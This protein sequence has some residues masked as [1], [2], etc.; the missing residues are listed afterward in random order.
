M[1]KLDIKYRFTSLDGAKIDRTARTVPLS[2]S[3]EFPAMQRNDF[4]TDI[5]RSA[6]LQKGQ[7]YIEVLDHTTENVDLSRLKNRGAF[8]DEHDEKDQIGVVETAEISNS[9]KIGR[10]VVKLDAH[11]KAT[12]RFS[13][14]ESNSRPHISAG[15]KYTRFLGDT[16]LPNGKKAKRFA[17]A[18]LELSSVAV[19]A[20]PTIGVSRSDHNF[21][22]VIDSSENLDV[23]AIAKN[24]TPEQKKRM[25]ILLNPDPAEGALT[26]ADVT[27]ARTE[28]ETAA[29]KAERARAGEITKVADELIKARKNLEPMIRNLASEALTTGMSLG[30][31]QIRAM[32]DVIA[33]KPTKELSAVEMGLSERDEKEYSIS[34][35][36]RSIIKA[37]LK[38]RLP[39]GLELEVHQEMVRRE[40]EDGG[41]IEASG[42]FVPSWAKVRMSPTGKMTRDL[43]AGVFGQGGATVA[44]QLQVPIIELLRNMMVT[45]G[46]GIRTLAGL[47]GNVVIP[48]QTAASTAYSVAETAAL[49]L[50]TQTLDQIALTPHRVGAV[51]RYSKQFLLQTSIDAE[52]FVR[53]DGLQVIALDWDRLIL[54]G[55]GA[56]S[57]MLGI[58]QTPG[59]GSIQFGGAATY[60]KLVSMETLAAAANV[61]LQPGSTAYCTTPTAKGVLKSAAKLLVGATTV[62]AV[63]IWDGDVVNG[64]Q[65]KASNQIPNNLM[66]FGDFSQFIHALWGGMDIVVDPYTLAPNAEVQ[67]SFNTF[68]DG[69]A[70][71]PQAFVLSTDSAAQ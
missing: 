11:E 25:K 26:A 5:T 16:I 13:Q 41:A 20:D 62:T 23:Q 39:D 44:T 54:N 22:E 28:G 38:S 31:F 52:N 21:P 40:K 34:R 46:L 51:Q 2:F 10:A 29:L 30:D 27:K 15:Y 37:G 61:M 53:D 36:I 70:R 24:L 43:T 18:A 63:S 4:E 48:R 3:S 9:E 50:S 42:F 55:S 33:A 6:G 67:V 49:T 56:A 1:A 59:I 58:M 7:V 12:T 68:G 32:K 65:S 19:P 8:L 69:V 64:Y 47:T 14:M 45:P 60:A 35:G 57:E 66:L 71:H 17:W